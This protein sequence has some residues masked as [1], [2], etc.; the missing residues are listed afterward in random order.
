MKASQEVKILNALQAAGFVVVQSWL[1][2][3][4]R[5]SSN[6]NGVTFTVDIEV[7]YVESGFILYVD[8]LPLT[9]NVNLYPEEN[10]QRFAELT[11]VLSRLNCAFNKNAG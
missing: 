8:P 6:L 3:A 5:V 9:C 11:L 1:S 7:Q 2:K 4:V 10:K